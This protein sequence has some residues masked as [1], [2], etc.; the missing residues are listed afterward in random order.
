MRGAVPKSQLADKELPP[1]LTD[2]IVL[3]APVHVSTIILMNVVSIHM[4]EAA[5]CLGGDDS[6][7]VCHLLSKNCLVSR[8]A[9]P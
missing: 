9:Q 7:Q 5:V 4:G 3:D 2:I 1:H 8:V 6:F